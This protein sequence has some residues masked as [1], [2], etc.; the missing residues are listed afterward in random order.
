MYPLCHTMKKVTADAVDLESCERGVFLWL[1][2]WLMC[3]KNT[4]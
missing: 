1:T 2:R 4:I 3:M